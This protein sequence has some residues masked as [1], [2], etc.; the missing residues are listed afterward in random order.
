MAETIKVALVYHNL[1]VGGVQKKI[2][3]IL[4]SAVES[5]K[6]ERIVLI[7]GKKTGIFLPLVPATVK[8]ID[9]GVDKNSNWY[10]LFPFKLLAAV[11]REKPDK[12]LA[13]MDVCG[14][15]ATLVK[16][17]LFWRKMKVDINENVMLS[18]FY[19]YRWLGGLR[20]FLVKIFYPGA[21]AVSAISESM[22]RDLI[23]N[24]GLL[25][26]KVIVIPNRMPPPFLKSQREKIKKDIDLLYAGRF[27]AEKNLMFLLKVFADVVKKKSETNLYL[28]GEGRDQRRLE[29]EIKRLNLTGKAVIAGPVADTQPYFRRAKIFV[30]TS[31]S[32]GVPLALLEAMAV[33]IPAVVPDIPVMRQLT[34]QEKGI[35]LVKGQRRFMETI[36]KLLENKS[37]ELYMR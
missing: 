25:S 22:R 10:L 33:G 35:I 36:L 17:L 24:F 16:K 26:T 27:E 37:L 5:K 4:Q 31:L 14:C 21:D 23:R 9:L 3:D 29:E 2:I 20:K 7:L 12:I 18:E 13:F 19:K 34:V 32:E 11:W 30:L 15:S 28:V 8:I 6:T 1:A